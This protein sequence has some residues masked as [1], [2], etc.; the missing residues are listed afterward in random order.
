ME[1]GSRSNGRQ[2]DKGAGWEGR[3][4]MQVSGCA[5][6]GSWGNSPSMASIFSEKKEV[7]SAVKQRGEH[8]RKVVAVWNS[9]G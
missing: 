1:K 9:R 6:I 3:I 7:T 2:W 5:R 8:R 4:E